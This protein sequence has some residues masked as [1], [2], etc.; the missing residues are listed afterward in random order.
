MA[1]ELAVAL[2][3]RYI[4]KIPKA[5]QSLP[6]VV[7]RELR[8][9]AE[10]RQFCS[11]AH[12]LLIDEHTRRDDQRREFSGRNQTMYNRAFFR[13]KLGQAALASIAAMTAFVALST[14]MQVSPA[15]AATPAYQQVEIA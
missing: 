11:L 14:Q 4:V 13:T 5:W 15:Y 12:P 8:K 9:P 10:I 2:H 6:Y 1:D 3:A 7:R